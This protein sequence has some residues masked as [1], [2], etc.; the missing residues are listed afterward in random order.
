MEI[1]DLFPE[2][3]D[4]N[5]KTPNNPKTVSQPTPPTKATNTQK[6]RSFAQAL[7]GVC[8]IPL[9]QLPNPVIKG[10]RPSITIPEEEY[11]AGIAE[12]KNNLHGRVLWKKGSTPL[13]VAAL[14]DKLALSWSEVK[15]WGMLS[16]GKGYYEFNFASPEDM[17]RV[18]AFGAINLNPGSLKLFAWTKDFNPSLQCNTSAQ[19]WIRLFGLSQ[20]YWRPRIVFAIA[21]CVGTPICIDAASSKSRVDRTFGQYVRV[22]VDMDLTK[23]LNHNVLVERT[24]F[25]FFADIEYENIP[26]FCEHCKKLGH[27]RQDCKS[28]M[29]QTNTSAPRTKSIYIQK[30][31]TSNT[32]TVEVPDTVL[33]GEVHP[34]LETI[35]NA[36]PI[37][38]PNPL[39]FISQPE[40]ETPATEFVDASQVLETQVDNFLHNSWADLADMEEEPGDTEGAFTNA[41]PI[42]KKKQAARNKAKR[43]SRSQAGPALS[44][45]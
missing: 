27:V 45:P 35:V 43:A 20:E 30:N 6:A 44:L 28:M 12:C 32:D 7:T 25:A 18:R 16:L 9:S 1:Q 33:R 41:V 29:K 8:D 40:P 37:I 36:D 38:V 2:T 23:T 3:R 24:G 11:E 10:D 22:L 34:I 19:V 13:T 31:S 21:S 42:I 17:R 4:E 14:K 15:N 5:T 39:N 26:P